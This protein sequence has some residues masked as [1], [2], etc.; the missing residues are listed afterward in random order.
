[1]SVASLLSAAAAG[2]CYWSCRMCGAG[3]RL[4]V[5]TRSLSSEW[6][7]TAAAV[8]VTCDI[9]LRRWMAPSWDGMGMLAFVQDL[10]LDVIGWFSLF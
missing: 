10:D 3:A 8:A 4:V 9:V 2:Y 5:R 6:D 1:L 7:W